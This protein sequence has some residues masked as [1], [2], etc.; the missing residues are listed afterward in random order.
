MVFFES[1]DLELSLKKALKRK[2]SATQKKKLQEGNREIKSV[3][4]KLGITLGKKTG[5][6]K[7]S[8]PRHQILFPATHF[9][10]FGQHGH[11]LASVENLIQ[12]KEGFQHS[13]SPFFWWGWGVKSYRLQ[14]LIFLRILTVGKM[15]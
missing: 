9:L 2:E 10:G 15:S 6:K 11:R 12:P 1:A 14:Q 7:T 13:N 8:N 5:K 3:W 4:A